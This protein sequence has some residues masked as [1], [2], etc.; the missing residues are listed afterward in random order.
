MKIRA[1]LTIALI[2]GLV[3]S[4]SAQET[5]TYTLTWSEVNAGTATPVASPNS[6]LDPGEGARI[7]V[8][9]EI[10]PGIGAP[11]TYTAPPAPGIGTIAGLG[12]IFF[13]LVQTNAQGGTWSVLA[14]PSPWTL[15]GAGTGNADGSLSA[16][17]A[18]QFVVPNNAAT[19]TNPVANIWRGTWTPASYTPRTVRFLAASAAAAQGNDSW[20]L[21]EYSSLQYIPK[22]VTGVFSFVDIPMSGSPCYA[23]CDASTVLPVLTAND[24]QCFLNKFASG[25]PYANCDGSTVPPV[26]TAND[27]Q[28]FLNAYATGC[29]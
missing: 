22:S 16:A 6:V 4:V 9:V 17:Q 5:V 29:Q 20:I 18:A 26:L 24:F 3:P 27:F 11:A 19:S 23:N 25:D 12:S 2:A 10:A 14:R 13:D 21:I 28:C 7:H 1:T 15:G 8:S